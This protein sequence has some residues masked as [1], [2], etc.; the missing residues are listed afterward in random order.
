MALCNNILDKM[1][2][3]KV[4]F[5]GALLVGLFVATLPAKQVRAYH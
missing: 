1:K 5:S 3:K 4:L 2:M